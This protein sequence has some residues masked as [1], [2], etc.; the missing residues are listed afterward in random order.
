MSN[1]EVAERCG[2]KELGA[3]LRGRSLGWFGHGVR[4]DEAKILGKTQLID[5]S[6]R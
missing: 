6:G 2:V 4:R 1:L 5:V 3:V